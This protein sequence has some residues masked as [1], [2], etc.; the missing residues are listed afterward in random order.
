LAEALSRGAEYVD[1]EARAHFDDLV[2]YAGGRRIVL[3]YHDFEGIPSDLP[4]LVRTMSAT[5]AEI[6]KVAAKTHSL[7]DCVSLRDAA[8]SAGRPEG[9]VLIGMGDFGLVTRV[10]P[11]RFG[12]AW[13]YARWDS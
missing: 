8:V 9:F 13:T 11:D 2:S 10:L 4:D 7:A 12:S 1:I 6:V 5:G 3:S